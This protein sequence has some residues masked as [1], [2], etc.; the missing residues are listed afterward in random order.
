[1]A[2]TMNTAGTA[3]SSTHSTRLRPQSVSPAR[4][5]ARS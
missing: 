2:K 1:V 4:I 5:A 3:A